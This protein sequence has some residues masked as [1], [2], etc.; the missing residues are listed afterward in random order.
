[1]LRHI[2]PSQQIPKVLIVLAAISALAGCNGIVKSSTTPQSQSPSPAALQISATSLPNGQVGDA[3]SGSLIATGGVAPY[4]WSV[5]TGSLPTGVSISASS[6]TVS[7][8][9][10]A[11]GSF[12]FAVGVQDSSAAKESV[13]SPSLSVK[14]ASAS[15][16]PTPAALQISTISLPNGQVGDAYGGSLVATG[17]TAPYHWSVAS[18]SLPT[19]ISINA[20]SGAV[21]GQPTAAG[22]F[23]FVIGVQDSS[24]AKASVN[25]PS[26]SV[27]I[28]SAPAAPVPPTPPATASTDYGPGIGAD[29]LGNTT[30]GP[31]Q[32]KLSYRLRLQ[33][34]GYISSVQPY[35]IMDHTGYWGG[36]SGQVLVSIQTDDGTSSHNP[37][38]QKLTSSLLIDPDA[39]P[40]PTRYFP[41][42]SFTGQASVTAGALY[43][44]VFENPDPNPTVNYVS[45]DALYQAGVP[46]PSQPTMSDTDCAVLLFANYSS[47]EG[48]VWKPRQGYTPIL[49]I[50]YDDGF[51]E[52]IG[53]MEVWV[54]A[55]QSISGTASVRETFTVSGPSDTVSS[56]SIR[57]AR[58]SGSASLTVRLETGNGTLIEQGEIPASSFPVSTSATYTW[59]VYKFATAHTL[60]N[61]Q[62][63][64]LVLQS[65]ASTVYQ[66]FPI[67]K[68]VDYGYKNTTYFPDGYAQ[69]LQNGTWVGW[70]QWG[71]TNRTD[72]DLQFYFAP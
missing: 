51:T 28:A 59:G 52:G 9:P 58:M 27:D 46:T 20:S 12:S 29:S 7:G 31:N 62:S 37:S 19:G 18:G 55:P 65:P 3:Y 17:G 33:H 21:S 72:G 42:F 67:R 24:V 60:A 34:T 69:F 1:L 57:A 61:G 71:V 40:T 70:T 45:V 50:N 63:Y 16:A 66:A 39:V 43:H 5:A 14:I 22:N 48:T 53:Y 35:L 15:A 41:T 49:Q 2:V 47:T 32:N 13:T 36:D 8:Q 23:N 11:A 68:G 44:V 10:T 38:G 56:V 6:G 25:S 26:M 4:H 30:I 54:G 64:H